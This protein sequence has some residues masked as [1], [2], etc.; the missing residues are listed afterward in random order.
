MP[1]L[2]LIK[3][4]F[5]DSKNVLLNFSQYLNNGLIPN[6]IAD[7]SGIPGYN[8]VDA[9]LWFVNAVWQYYKYTSDAEFIRDELWFK[10]Q[11]IIDFH[12]KG[13]FFGIH[14]DSDGLLMHGARLTWMDA[15]EN[16]DAI[17]ARAGKA[18]EIQALWYNT[19]KIMETLAGKFKEDYLEAKYQQMASQAAESFNSKFWNPNLNCLFDVLSPNGTDASLRPN[20]IFAVSL[21]FGMLDKEK[22]KLVVAAVQ[23]SLVT[24]YGLRTLSLEDPKFVGMCTGER[25]SRDKAYHNGTIWPWLLGPFISAYVKVNDYS[26]ASRDFAAQNYVV[27]LLRVAVGQ[28]GL[29]TVSEIYDC[30][31]PNAPRGCISQAWSV[32]EPLRA[33]IEDVLM[34]RPAPSLNGKY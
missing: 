27:P 31:P 20:Q 21:D 16:G 30:D 6:L 14:L 8:T 12:E 7:N 1:G 29:G 4:R 5:L 25:A 2:L 13:T 11:S 28:A 9:T 26:A 19:L 17:T 34:I 10:L 33:Y 18:V 32:A 3:G 24:S 15:M 22:S 23:N